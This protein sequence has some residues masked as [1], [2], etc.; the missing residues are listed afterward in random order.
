MLDIMHSLM[1]L[2]ANERGA[3]SSLNESLNAS[4]SE[5]LNDGDQVRFRR[6]MRCFPSVLPLCPPISGW[7]SVVLWR[8]SAERWTHRGH[9]ED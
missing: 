8:N 3:M 6:V 4:P 7:A 2:R 1:R 5:S 9:R